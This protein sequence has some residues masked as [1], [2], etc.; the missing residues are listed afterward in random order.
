MTQIP[1]LLDQ[2]A[3]KRNRDRA[4][5]APDGS[6]FLFVES[7]DR[8]LDR[9]DDIRRTFPVAL[10]LGCRWGEIAATIAGR[11]QVE[12][13]YQ[14][15]I[16]PAMCIA[17]RKRNPDVATFCAEEEAP[18]LPPASLDLLLSNLDFHGLNDLPG[19]MARVRD[20]LRPGGAVLV[21]LLGAE[22]LFELRECLV[23][24]E[25][26]LSGQASPRVSPTIG[27]KDL[28][29]LAARAGFVDSTVDLDALTVRYERPLNLL[30]D[31]RHMG[32]ANA[33]SERTR[34]GLR[35]DV[36]SRTL[37]IYEKRF[38]GADG[39]V[40]ATFQILTLTAWRRG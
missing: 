40:P 22:T 29:D 38:G 16:S 14:S 36:L 9:L 27:V 8:L 25:M 17:A 7:A 12:T 24:A 2:A 35:R 18:P 39:R 23:E 19:A 26:N 30:R 11:G 1:P 21:S 13:L 5:T 37:E 4:A 32:E 33:L 28:G 20:L 3:R 10:D 6:D 34:L 15:D 31:L